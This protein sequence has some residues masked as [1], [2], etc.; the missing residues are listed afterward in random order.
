VKRLVKDIAVIAATAG[1][2]AAVVLTWSNFI[3]PA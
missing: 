3:R 1:S 2:V